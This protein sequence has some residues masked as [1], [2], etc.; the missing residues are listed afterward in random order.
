MRA[1]SGAGRAVIDIAFGIEGRL[2]PESDRVDPALQPFAHREPLCG[3]EE[4]VRDVLREL[5]MLRRTAAVGEPLP[6][7]EQVENGL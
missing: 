6:G 4:A 5:A 1:G 3:G 2:A 7:L